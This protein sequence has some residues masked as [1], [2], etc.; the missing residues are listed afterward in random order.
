[1][2]LR[3]LSEAVYSHSSFQASSRVGI[4]LSPNRADSVAQSEESAARPRRISLGVKLA[5]GWE[6]RFLR[7]HTRRCPH[8]HER[9]ASGT[10]LHRQTPPHSKLIPLDEP[11]FLWYSSFWVQL[12]LI[13][14]ARPCPSTPRN[15]REMCTILVQYKSF[16]CNTSVP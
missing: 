10:P 4:R 15:K 6:D 8:R 16:R 12:Q 14:S 9:L 11:I 2:C 3:K 7:I 1:M 13:P 5:P